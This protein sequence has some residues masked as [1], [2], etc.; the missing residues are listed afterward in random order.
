MFIQNNFLY[1]LKNIFKCINGGYFMSSKCIFIFISNSSC[2]N[3]MH[4]LCI[5]LLH[6]RKTF[7]FYEINKIINIKYTYENNNKI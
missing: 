4:V 1:S 3:N 2:C 7:K 5:V 6:C